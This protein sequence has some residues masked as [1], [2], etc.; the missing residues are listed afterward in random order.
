MLRSVLVGMYSKQIEKQ[1]IDDIL[2]EMKLGEMARAEELP[3][4]T[5][6]ELANAIYHKIKEGEPSQS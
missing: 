2:Q 6:V 1:V 3:P 5:L 4:K